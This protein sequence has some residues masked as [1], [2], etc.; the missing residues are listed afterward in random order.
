MFTEK[1]NR[2]QF[3]YYSSFLL[4]IVIPILFIIIGS[5]AIV[6]TMMLR[7]ATDKIEL[8]QANVEKTLEEEIDN[9][10]M[11]LSHLC[12]VNNS[13]VLALASK[14]DDTN[15]FNKY[16]FEKILRETFNYMMIPS[17]DMLASVF[18]MVSGDNTYIKDDLVIPQTEIRQSKWYQQ[19]LSNKNN[20]CIGS[21]SSKVTYS[22]KTKY[23]FTIA[24]GLSPDNSLDRTNKIEM[25]TLFIQS[26]IGNMMREYNKEKSLG[27]MYLVDENKEVLLN[28]SDEELVLPNNLD[29]NQSIVREH[30]EG[31]A[32]TYLMKEISPTGWKLVSVVDSQILLEEFNKIA[33]IITVI[34]VVLFMLFYLFSSIFL[35]RI[36][37]PVNEVIEGLKQ[38]EGGSLEVH[39]PISGQSEIRTMIHSF[40]RM[41]RR[42]K[43]LIRDNEQQQQMKHEAE[44][45]A[46]QS[47]INPH[48]LVNTLSSIR[49]MAQVSKFDGIKNMAE[50]L[51]RIL[52][53][54]FRRNGSFYTLKEEL[55]VLSSYIFLM[56]VRYSDGFDYTADV[57]EGCMEDL[58]PRLILQPIIENCIVHG[59]SEMEDIGEIQL[60]AY[61]EEDRLCIVIEDNGK[62][63]TEAQISEILKPKEDKEDNYSIGISNVYSRLKLNFGDACEMRIV[64]EPG[65]YTRTTIEIPRKST[66]Q[67][68]QIV[69]RD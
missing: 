41:V 34:T 60:R 17:D 8:V 58:V 67:N 16:N 59:F 28:V 24:A 47:Q 32:F 55:E 39:I 6:R 49:F 30:T 43:V 66:K 10:S 18:Y 68:V 2:L 26:E 69:T 7:S 36:I 22:L 13:D 61:Q 51:I 35:K 15:A 63:M 5:F 12:N 50:A 52:S 3:T 4:L 1:K 62:G 65:K 11:R 31:T 38:V 46:L 27:T 29:L 42:L 45:R 56:K 44:I 21:Y 53:C 19:A 48:F 14:T 54:S 64:S 57:G 9:V 25:A 20:V 23:Q 37:H 40:N 33:G